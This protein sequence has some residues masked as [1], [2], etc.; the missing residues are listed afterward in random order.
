M[1]RRFA[2]RETT[3]SPSLINN[4]TLISLYLLKKKSDVGFLQHLINS[5]NIW[6][7]SFFQ[8]HHINRSPTKGFFFSLADLMKYLHKW[9]A[10]APIHHTFVLK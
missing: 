8:T 7:S 5:G 9:L 10:S 3:L 2:D 4:V 6:K 1:G